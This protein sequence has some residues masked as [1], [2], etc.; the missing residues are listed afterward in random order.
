MKS[1]HKSKNYKYNICKDVMAREAHITIGDLLEILTFRQ[2]MHEG[3]TNAGKSVDFKITKVNSIT[4]DEPEEMTSAYVTCEIE[5]QI[6]EA[7]IDTGA[8]SSFVM[9]KTTDCLGWRI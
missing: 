2:Q 7:V 5:H 1:L 4:N 3:V 8:R 9:K 6:F